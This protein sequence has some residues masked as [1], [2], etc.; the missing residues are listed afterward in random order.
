MK[1]YIIVETMEGR[2]RY[3]PQSFLL[4]NGHLGLKVRLKPICIISK[5]QV[6]YH[7]N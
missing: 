5:R 3:T 7:E 4:D 2:H 6:Q 1:I